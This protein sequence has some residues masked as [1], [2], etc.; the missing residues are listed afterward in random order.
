MTYDLKAL[1]A[2]LGKRIAEQNLAGVTVCLRGPEGVIFEKGYGYCDENKRPINE[3][4]VMGIA[5]MSK[6]TV[7]D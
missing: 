4:T 5:S 6:S 1:D 7:T 3:H 2:A